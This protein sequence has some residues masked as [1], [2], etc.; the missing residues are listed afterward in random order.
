MELFLDNDIILKLSAAGL[1]EKL[2]EIYNVDASSIYVLP[3][4]PYYFRNNPKFEK[5]YDSETIKQAK[6]AAEKY[7]IIPNKY[8]EFEKSIRLDAIERIDSGELTLYSLSPESEEFFILT[9]DKNSIRALNNAEGVDDIK[10]YLKEKIVFLEELML[11]FIEK[12]SFEKIFKS[13]SAANF[14]YDIVVRNCFNQTN[15][16]E[17]KVVD[18]LKSYSNN[19]KQICTNLFK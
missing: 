12:E 1:L 5:K 9:G 8:I 19:L 13:V 14:C 17:E 4:A 10:A 18:C 2:E 6:E 15:V 16:D 11:V 7:S 3:S